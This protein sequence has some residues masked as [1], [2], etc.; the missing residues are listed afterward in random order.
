MENNIEELKN[1]DGKLKILIESDDEGSWNV[2]YQIL[3]LKYKE[4]DI[5]GFKLQKMLYERWKEENNQQMTDDTH[6]I[7]NKIKNYTVTCEDFEMSYFE[8]KMN[9][10]WRWG[11]SGTSWTNTVYRYGGRRKKQL[12]V[13]VKQNR[14]KLTR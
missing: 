2:A 3:L 8:H 10:S 4:T 12:P 9:S 1:L 13:A 14:N 6:E 11:T 5:A 7:L